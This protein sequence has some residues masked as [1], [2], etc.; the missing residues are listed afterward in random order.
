MLPRWTGPKLIDCAFRIPHCH[1]GLPRHETCDWN[2]DEDHRTVRECDPYISKLELLFYATSIHLQMSDPM[3]PLSEVKDPSVDESKLTEQELKLYRMYGKIPKRSEILKSKFKDR[4][5]FDSGDYAMSKAGVK[6]GVEVN[7][8]LN[9]LKLSGIEEISR[10]NRN[11]IC[12]V[13][14][15]LVNGKSHLERESTNDQ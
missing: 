7:S 14:N 1:C 2:P 11:S 9:P 10:V 6:Q 5:F 3:D 8:S 4:K 15:P 12:N 13:N